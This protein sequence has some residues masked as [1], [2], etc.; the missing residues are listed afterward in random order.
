MKELD[1]HGLP[2]HH[3]RNIQ[4]GVARA[5]VFGISDGLVSNIAL[6][7]GVAGAGPAPSVVR[8]AGLVGL[9]GGAFSMAAGEYVSMRAQTELLEAELELERHELARRPENEQRELAQ[10][11]KARGVE[12]DIAERLAAEMMSDP[13]LALETHAREEL[14]I[15]PNQLGSPPGAAVSSFIAFAIGASAP[16][17][18]WFVTR[19]VLA[20]LLSIIVGV[21]GSIAIGFALA[22]ATKRSPWRSCI[23]QVFIAA[24]AA[25]VPYALG[26]VVGV[27]AG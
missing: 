20:E 21:I 23:R 22:R 18:P 11:Y 1:G 13:D 4:G 26:H 2:D 25:G 5:A 3:H 15:D 7:L 9:V 27:T 19:G 14:G 6:V 24:L 12:P 8:L 10:I 17:L 16:L